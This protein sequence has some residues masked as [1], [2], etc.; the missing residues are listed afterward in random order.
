M[1]LYSCIPEE[2]LKMTSGIE[3]AWNVF[4]ALQRLIMISSDTMMLS[5]PAWLS[6]FPIFPPFSYNQLI[7]EKKTF[8]LTA[9]SP[10][11]L[12][13][14]IRVLQNILKVQASSPVA[15]ETTAKPTVR[16]WL[17]KVRGQKKIKTWF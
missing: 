11:I 13:E 3:V 15:V 12:E 1:E 9:D 5:R 16:G 14:W 17:T 2:Q 8:Y 7:T 10:N 6:I 4:L